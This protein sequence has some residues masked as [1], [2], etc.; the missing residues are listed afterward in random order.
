MKKT[1]K[2]TIIIISSMVFMSFIFFAF[3]PGNQKPWTIPAK[4]KTLKNPV[5]SDATNIN[6]GKD[7]Y[8]KHCKA[9]HGAKGLGDG[10]KATTLKSKIP[11]FADKTFKSQPVGEIYY[12]AIIGMDEMP[13][14]EK[15]ILDESERWS[16]INYLLSL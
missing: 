10:P 1:F 14:F 13:N 5:K 2:N 3:T 7:I 4:Y 16:V 8:A 6:V 11:S 15:K 12:K 9:C